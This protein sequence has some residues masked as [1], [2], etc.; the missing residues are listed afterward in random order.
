MDEIPDFNA[1]PQK[2]GAMQP[3]NGVYTMAPTAIP[4]P[5]LSLQKATSPPVVVTIT[6]NGQKEDDIPVLEATR[7]GAFHSDFDEDDDDDDDGE[8]IIVGG[9][10]SDDD[11]DDGDDDEFNEDD[12]VPVLQTIEDA[13]AFDKAMRQRPIGSRKFSWRESSRKVAKRKSSRAKKSPHVPDPETLLRMS[14]Q[15]TELTS[16]SSSGSL[17]SRKASSISVDKQLIRSGWLYKQ[18]DIMYV[19]FAMHGV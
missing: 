5:A 10:D 6:S 2:N 18:A 4:M 1:R 9:E 11:D 17:I 19:H 3:N 13:Q 15:S 14:S 16:N 7:D 8:D 12:Y